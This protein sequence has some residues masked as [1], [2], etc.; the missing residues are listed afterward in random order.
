MY[1]FFKVHI[2]NARQLAIRTAENSL[3][4][5]KTNRIR[6]VHW[7][8]VGYI[9][10]WYKNIII[11]NYRNI[12]LSHIQLQQSIVFNQYQSP[13][14]GIQ[15]L[16]EGMAVSLPLLSLGYSRWRAFFYGQLSGMVEP[17][18]A[19]VGAL[20]VTALSIIQPYALGF[21][22]GAMIY[23]VYEVYLCLYFITGCGK[24]R[25]IVRMITKSLFPAC[26]V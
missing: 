5:L 3:K 13:G 26:W 24:V 7:L 22:A 12:F 17:F 21:A 1:N 9:K 18:A 2:K 15:N 23:V 6:E 11:Y 8:F 10:N 4:Q 25:D 16:P 20:A 19:F 14:M